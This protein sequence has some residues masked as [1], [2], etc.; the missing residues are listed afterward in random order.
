MI[1]P[2]DKLIETMAEKIYVMSTHLTTIAERKVTNPPPMDATMDDIMKW[3]FTRVYEENDCDLEKVS[4]ILG[5][6]VKTLYNW[7]A[8]WGMK[9]IPLKENTGK[10]N[11]SGR[12]RKH[13][14]RTGF[15]A[16]FDKPLSFFQSTKD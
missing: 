14:N 8:K 12:T 3:A 16:R 11:H 2:R 7:R 9:I 6:S 10:V 5:V 13:K 15:K 4:K 1:D